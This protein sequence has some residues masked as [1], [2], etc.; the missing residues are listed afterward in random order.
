M[1]VD[2]VGFVVTSGTWEGGQPVGPSTSRYSN[3]DVYVGACKAH[4]REG[5]GRCEYAN[6]D[7]YEGEWLGDEPHGV[8]TMRSRAVLFV[9][10]NLHLTCISPASHLHLTCHQGRVERQRGEQRG[11]Q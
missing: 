11:E 1:A 7:A 9:A 5:S 8:G 2:A 4:V 3:G 10:S 6:G